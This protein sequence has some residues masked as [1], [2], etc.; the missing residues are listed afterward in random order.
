MYRQANSQ[1]TP[2]LLVPPLVGERSSFRTIIP[3]SYPWKRSFP[4]YLSTRVTLL[5]WGTRLS[6]RTLQG[7]KGSAEGSEGESRTGASL[8]PNAPAL[9]KPR[10]LSQHLDALSN[11]WLLTES[12]WERETACLRSGTVR[13]EV[14]STHTHFSAWTCSPNERSRALTLSGFA[15]ALLQGV[16]FTRLVQSTRHI[17]IFFPLS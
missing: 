9:C 5:S 6:L 11:P 15:L 17:K 1:Q 2:L 7:D 12:S 8:G 4:S 10:A 13:G 3:F 14:I 16:H